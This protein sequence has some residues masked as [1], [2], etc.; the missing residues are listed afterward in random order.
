MKYIVLAIFLF[1]SCSNYNFNECTKSEF[2][3]SVS[4]DL[5]DNHSKTRIDTIVFND[6][7]KLIF[8]SYCWPSGKM[9]L[10]SAV[11]FSEEGKSIDCFEYLSGRLTDRQLGQINNNILLDV[12]LSGNYINEKKLKNLISPKCNNT[13]NELIELLDSADK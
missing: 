9:S 10:I 4:Y 3:H 8:Q 1:S 6:S 7:R 5:N 13:K 12:F 11:F 2:R